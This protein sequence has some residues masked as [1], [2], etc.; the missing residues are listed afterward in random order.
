MTERIYTQEQL[1]ALPEQ[2][3]EAQKIRALFLAYGGSYDF[4]RF[5]RQADTYLAA[6]DGSFVIAE[7]PGADYEEIAQFLCMHGFTD[8]FCSDETGNRLKPLIPAEFTPGQLMV[9]CGEKHG[10]FPPECTPMEAW[11]VIGSRFDIPFEPWYLDISHRV[12]HGVT[13]CISDGRATLVIQHEINGESL[14]SQ[15][16]VLPEY[17]HRG[18]AGELVRSVS[19]AISGKVQLICEESLC[20]FY[21]KCGYRKGSQ[22]Y[23]AVA[24]G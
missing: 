23:I 8:I 2:G 1:S 16:C 24:L 6:L 14:I 11:S 22:K 13:R 19:A 3:V 17:E 20:G 21:E 4:C 10:G 12:R 5:Y 15:V 18:I 9:Y 7:Q